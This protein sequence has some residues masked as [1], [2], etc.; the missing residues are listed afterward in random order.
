M[1]ERDMTRFFHECIDDPLLGVLIL[2]ALLFVVVMS[3]LV[4]QDRIKRR[5]VQERLQ[6]KRGEIKEK[7]AKGIKI[8]EGLK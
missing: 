5:Q 8:E 2:A 1:N 7:R 4:L 3:W 6:R